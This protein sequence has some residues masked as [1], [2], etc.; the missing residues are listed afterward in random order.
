M[1]LAACSKTS[2]MVSK[3]CPKAPD[4]AHVL[5]S[6]A[7]RQLQLR[8]TTAKVLTCMLPTSCPTAADF[9]GPGCFY[10]AATT[11]A[12]ESYCWLIRP[13]G[14]TAVDCT[15]LARVAVGSKEGGNSSQECILAA[16]LEPAQQG[17]GMV[18]L[19]CTSALVANVF[20]QWVLLRSC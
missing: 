12:G 10:A 20:E 1:E 9:E 7:P 15:Q 11:S 14:E 19:C 4:S 16:A 2:L 18:I 8:F 13:Q 5:S 6:T 3:A 17:E